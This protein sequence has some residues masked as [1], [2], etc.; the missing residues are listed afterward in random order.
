MESKVETGHRVWAVVKLIK[1][2]LW[3]FKRKALLEFALVGVPRKGLSVS[4]LS[5]LK[6]NKFQ[7]MLHVK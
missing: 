1:N 2:R 3:G 5:S 7:Q 4:S 6:W